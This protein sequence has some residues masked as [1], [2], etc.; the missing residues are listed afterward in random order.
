[1][2]TLSTTR[3]TPAAN[4]MHTRTVKHRLRF[5]ARLSCDKVVRAHVDDDDPSSSAGLS[6]G[7]ERAVSCD[8][9]ESSTSSS[10]VLAMY[11]SFV[12]FVGLPLLRRGGADPLAACAPLEDFMDPNECE[13][14]VP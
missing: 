6:L 2:V 8:D 7:D 12:L 3:A 1:M 10:S 4:T 9:V 11:M 14:Y 13:R 5:R